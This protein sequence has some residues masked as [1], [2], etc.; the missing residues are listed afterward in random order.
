MGPGAGMSA[1]FGDNRP[2]Y[3][4]VDPPGKHDRF[5][6]YSTHG[7]SGWRIAKSPYS[8][9]FYISKFKIITSLGIPSNLFYMGLMGLL[10]TSLSS[11]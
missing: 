6:Y 1:A 10:D 3:K 2:V 11:I 4:R 8:G 7:G 9:L 5:L